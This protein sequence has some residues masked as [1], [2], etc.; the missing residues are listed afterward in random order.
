M[1]FKKDFF[2]SSIGKKMIMGMLGLFLSLFLIIH[3]IGNLFLYVGEEAFNRYAYMLTSTKLF[4]IMEVSLLSLFLFHAVMGVFLVIQN[5]RARGAQGY[6]V[7]K[8]TGKGSTIFSSSMPYTGALLLIFIVLHVIHFRFGTHY[9]VMYSDGVQMRNLYRLVL[10]FFTSPYNTLFYVFSMIILA[11]HL[12]H[13]VQSAFQSL[14]LRTK[15][16]EPLIKLIGYLFVALVLFGF[17]SFPIWSY[18][19][20]GY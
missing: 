7:R 16:Y 12:L 3:F 8:E 2:L 18:L 13:G 14:S 11:G 19:K 6:A 20:G 10:E 15:S 1:I 5:K 4:P 17:T 9:S